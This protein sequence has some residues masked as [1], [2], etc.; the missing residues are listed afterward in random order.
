[1]R[2]VQGYHFCSEE[3]ARIGFDHS[4]KLDSL[5]TL[6]QLCACE[7]CRSFL[8]RTPNLRKLGLK[9]NEKLGDGSFMS[10]DLE[11]L[12]CLETL[13]ITGVI[14]TE[15]WKLPLTVKRLTLVATSLKWEEVSILQKLPSLEV[16]KLECNACKG[17]VWETSGEGFSQL[18]YLSF[19]EM[20]EIEEWNASEDQ[21]P[22]LEVLV[23]ENCR[24]LERIPIDFANLNE[25]REIR[26]L[27]CSWSLE[28][29]AREIQ[30]K[31]DDD[32]LNLIAKSNGWV[33]NDDTN[34]FSWRS[35]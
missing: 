29:S 11:F 35:E 8:V 34:E 26:L 15:C 33:W 31:R 5:Q 17:P 18:K 19:D 6:H 10:L 12:K 13:S 7:D 23:L 21:F 2:F 22:R 9:Q 20:D 14:P 24:K 32:C 1:M 4:S 3:A 27:L 28:K 25:L 30:E 16:L